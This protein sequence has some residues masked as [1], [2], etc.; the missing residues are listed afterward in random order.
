MDIEKGSPG[1]RKSTGEALSRTE[2]ESRERIRRMVEGDQLPQEQ[3]EGERGVDRRV[4][5]GRF[6]Q[7]ELSDRT[8][9]TGGESDTVAG[10]AVS[11]IT[12]DDAD[13]GA[14]LPEDE[15]EKARKSGVG[16]AIRWL[17]EWIERQ[18]RKL[19]L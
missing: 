8:S 10:P 2:K 18:R 19:K 9:H 6:Q 12:T 5:E 16:K 14:V 4:T 13:S 7:E 3:Q 17:A 11:D 15:E 1:R